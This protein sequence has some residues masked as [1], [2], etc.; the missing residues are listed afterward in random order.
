MVSF[1]WGG[2]GGG[3]SFCPHIQSLSIIQ[4]CTAFFVMAYSIIIL[5]CLSK[6]VTAVVTG[7][8]VTFSQHG[9]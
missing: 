9:Q 3:I 5:W 8:Q 2:G 7:L 6:E 1:F 4:K